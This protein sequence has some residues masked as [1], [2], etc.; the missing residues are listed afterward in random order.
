MGR[1]R[2]WSE[3][4]P[5]E[6]LRSAR[7]IELCRRFGLEVL[8]AA[9]PGAVASIAGVVAAYRE[10]GLFVGVWPML[11]DAAGRWASARSAAAFAAHCHR[12]LDRLD[13]E[14]SWPDE[15]ALDLEPPFEDVRRLL[16]GS[17]PGAI[18]IRGRSS[19]GAIRI[20]GRSSA[21]AD[22]SASPSAIGSPARSTGLTLA[23]VLD[24]AP[25]PEELDAARRALAGLCARAEA[26]GAAV[27]AA[28]VPL[29][30]GAPAWEALLGTPV[31]G[32]AIGHVS[33][34][35]YTSIV[36]GWSRGLC[37]RR[38]AVALLAAGCRAA[39]ASFGSRAGVS[40]GAVG[41]GAFGDEPVYRSPA[42]LA[43][44]VAVARASGVSDLTLLD[45]G[46]VLARPP[47]E[48]WLEAFVH[49]AAAS[50]VPPAPRRVRAGLAV[51]GL[52]GRALG[53]VSRQASGG[54]RGRHV[55]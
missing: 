27:S 55:P 41:L 32:L 7:V 36:E 35:L 22:G 5:H 43:E 46:G 25:S 3:D 45:L 19:P 4:V 40:L 38:D 24:L 8:V 31:R 12:L 17:S 30:V 28:V 20:R 9:R 51:L 53:A 6:T 50:K 33:S 26:G 34:M 44:D 52:T 23:R 39:R 14:G 21:G 1:R 49:T 2:I 18:R 47:A 11:D 29:V 54:P 10:A 15:L 13:A 42:E 37:R 48:A 16:A